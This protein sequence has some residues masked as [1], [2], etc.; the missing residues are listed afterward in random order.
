MIFA[1]LLLALI[2]I[3]VVGF[4]LVDNTPPTVQVT[5]LVVYAPDNVCGL[6]THPGAYGGFNDSPGDHLPIELEV[7]NYNLTSCSIA[8]ISTN[9]SGFQVTNAQ[10]HVVISGG[11]D[12][13]FNL[14]LALPGTT[15]VG[16]VNLVF[17]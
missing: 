4:Y 1:V 17:R 8:G 13:T 3:G 9:T 16:V 11:S 2:L 7:A 15:F 6:R 10:A 14:T 12:G 5:A